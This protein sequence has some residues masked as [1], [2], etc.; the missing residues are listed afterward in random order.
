MGRT[1]RR[2]LLALVACVVTASAFPATAQPAAAPPPVQ[3]KGPALV[4]AL[5]AGGYVLYF[6][7]TATDFSQRDDKMTDHEDCAHQRNLNDR[8]RADARAIGA[9][10]RALKIPVGDVLASPFCRT[11]ETAQLIFDR[12]AASAA[13]RGG[14]TDTGSPGQYAA[15]RALLS[16]TVSRGTNLVLVAHGNPYRAILGGAYLAEGEVAVVEPRGKDGFREVARVQ[17]EEW[18]ALETVTK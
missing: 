3:L 4:A 6:R 11:I 2:F 10:M 12:A 9:S 17:L 16:S 1:T 15:L 13:L 5:R 18:R 7:H 8:G 14:P